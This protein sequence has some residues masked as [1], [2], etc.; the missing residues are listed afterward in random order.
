MENHPIPQDITGFQFKLI[1][2]MTVKQFAYVAAGVIMA[3]IFFILPIFAIIKITLA[4][5]AAAIG[6][7]LAFVP[8]EGRP[9]DLMIGNFFKA[10][11]NPTLYIY[12]KQAA[13]NTL[14]PSNTQ[15][16]DTTSSPNLSSLYQG[17]FR[18]FIKKLPKKQSRLD[19]KE[20]AFFQNL[21]Y[22]SLMPK[23]NPQPAPMPAHMFADKNVA[24]IPS[25]NI[26]EPVKAESQD[27][28]K[29][30]E[31]LKKNAEVLATE[32][33]KAKQQEVTQSQ[34]DP[35][36]YLEAHQKV[37]DLQKQL[38]DMLSQKQQLEQRLV[39]IQKGMQTKSPV[40]SPSIATEAP[41]QTKNV[42]SVPQS[43]GNSVGLP[44]T[45]E[46]PNVV[47]GIVKDP[48]GN[49]LPNVL[50]EVKDDQGNAVRAFKTNALGHFASATPLVNG[51]YTI[52]FEDTN[53][54]NRFDTIAFSADNNVIM[55]I[56]VISN[57][58]REELRKELFN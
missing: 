57:D 29:T 19:K 5:V 20:Q 40:F 6:A 55:P 3:W 41:T 28:V 51:N 58:A 1:G 37:L 36:P 47:T 18:D 24:P 35:K 31:E 30:E 11:F 17:Q 25:M 43:M 52:G 22:Y 39:D 7:S 21:N 13:L 10:I 26:H 27:V 45:P 44:L 46:F 9:M 14:P 34:V 2:N 15:V 23:P 56:E 48:R 33:Q 32:L 50:V 4:L 49:P 54:Q 12:Q 16:K 53:G 42:R 38:N 8:I